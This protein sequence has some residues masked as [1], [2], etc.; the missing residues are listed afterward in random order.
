M[1][2]QFIPGELLRSFATV[3][4]SGSFTGAARTLGLR[5]ST[6]SQHIARLEARIDRRL[7]DRDTHHLSLTPAGEALLTHAANILDAQDRL[8][9]HLSATPLRGRLRLGA[10]EDFVFS[11]LPDVLANFARR[12]PE[13]D[14]ELHAGLSETLYDAFDSGR[15]D[16]LF[17]KRRQG[18]RRGITAWREAI[19]WAGASSF[20]PKRGSPVPLLLYPA[21][22]VTRAIAIETLETAGIAWRV[23]FTS[24]S[25]SGL[26]A[27]ARAG[28]GLMPHSARLLPT[29]LANAPRTGILPSMPEIEFVVVAPSGSEPARDALVEMMLQ[30]ARRST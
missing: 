2:D 25:L 14:L 12:H 6:V 20:R 29:E 1:A 17:V 26:V 23:A 13:V 18:D 10:S 11:A 19:V 7:I 4:A 27:A 15:L 9:R 5:Q 30:W 24:A 8:Q 16:L 22:S 3:A 28:I 21:P